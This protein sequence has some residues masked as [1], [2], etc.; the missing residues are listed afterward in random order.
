MGFEKEL[1]DKPLNADFIFISTY[2]NYRKEESGIKSNHVLEIEHIN[3]K[4]LKRIV[5]MCKKEEY[6][7]VKIR[8]G[9]TNE[10]FMRKITDITFWNSLVIISW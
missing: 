7:Y 8:K 3:E 10:T 1:K 5:E 6:G 2:S 9:Y 4:W